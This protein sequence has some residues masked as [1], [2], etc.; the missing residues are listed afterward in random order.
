MAKRGFHHR[1][2]FGHDHPW[3]QIIR[4]LLAPGTGAKPGML[5]T[6]GVEQFL[7]ALELGERWAQEILRP[8]VH[9]VMVRDISNESTY[10][11][12]AARFRSLATGKEVV[13]PN[14][15][16][17]RPRRDDGAIENYSQR[18]FF[19]DLPRASALD[20]LLREQ[21]EVDTH[22]GKVAAY[23]YYLA[24][25]DAHPEAETARDACALAGIDPF[26]ILDADQQAI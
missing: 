16:G 12:G 22:S 11:G 3:Q 19:I 1:E 4:E 15:V 8:I 14:E 18:C 25:W 9:E 17:I 10:Q 6:L 24:V 21:Q 23:E 13:L 5:A 26:N 7:I 20:V 2:R